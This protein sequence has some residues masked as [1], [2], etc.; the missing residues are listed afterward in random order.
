MNGVA[1]TT[2]EEGLTLGDIEE[3]FDGPPSAHGAAKRQLLLAA[4]R[5][6]LARGPGAADWG[7]EAAAIAV[8]CRRM[9]DVTSKDGDEAAEAAAFTL[10][11]AYMED[12]GRDL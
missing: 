1:D 3:H 7:A 10:A 4:L 5:S 2:G 11:T 12:L 6:A 8:K 9:A